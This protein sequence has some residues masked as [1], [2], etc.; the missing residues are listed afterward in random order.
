MSRGELADLRRRRIG[1]V[2]QQP[3]LLPS[4]PRPSNSR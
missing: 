3:N 2:F 1:I 4:L